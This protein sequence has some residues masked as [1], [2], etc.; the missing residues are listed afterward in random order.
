MTIKAIDY[1]SLKKYFEK[2]NV[3]IDNQ[4]SEF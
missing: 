2:Y 1:Q 4:Y 3:R